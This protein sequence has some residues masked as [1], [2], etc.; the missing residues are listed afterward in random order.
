MCSTAQSPRAW[1]AF[2]RAWAARTCPA[3][4]VAESNNTRGFGFIFRDF[5]QTQAALG[6]LA[7]TRGDF[8]Q[9]SA[10]DFL[11]FAE[12]RQ[13]ILKIVIEELRVLRPQ[14]G[15]QNHVTQFYGMRKQRLFLQF[16]EGN[17][18]VVVIHEFPPAEKSF[19]R[20]VLSCCR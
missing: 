10:S 16:L 13:V 1:K 8:F 6:C 3:P 12:P 5:L 20:I 7:L 11:Q 14:L 2:S 9:D 19:H 18:G 4:D 17:L 15:P